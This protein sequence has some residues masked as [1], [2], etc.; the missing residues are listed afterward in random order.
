MSNA[1]VECDCSSLM[2]FVSLVAVWVVESM[3]NPSQQF[4]YDL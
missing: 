3:H 2:I 1:T 4:V